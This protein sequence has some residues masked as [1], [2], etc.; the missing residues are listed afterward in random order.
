MFQPHSDSAVAQRCVATYKAMEGRAWRRE[1]PWEQRERSNYIIHR[2]PPVRADL[3]T[4]RLNLPKYPLWRCASQS[5]LCAVRNNPMLRIRSPLKTK[6]SQW[7]CEQTTRRVV[8]LLQLK[9]T[10]SIN[11]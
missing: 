5:R 6:A 4:H 9:M 2:P 10:S 3:M 11:C 1:Q 8:I 7:L